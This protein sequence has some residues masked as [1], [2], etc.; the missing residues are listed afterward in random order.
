MIAKERDYPINIAKLEVLLK[1][2]PQTHP[3]YKDVQL[4]LYKKT[5][6]FRG[7]QNTDYPLSFLSPN[8]YYILHDLRLPVEHYYFQI[9]T[10]IL[11]K[12]LLI[13]LEIKNVAGTL[14]FDQDF[15]QL[16]KIHEGNEEA[17]S[18]PIIQVARQKLL[19]EKWLATKYYSDLPIENLI[20]ISN[21]QTIIKT[22]PPGLKIPKN[23]IN[24]DSLPFE[25]SK[26]EKKYKREL[27]TD[28]EIKKLIRQLKKD[29]TPT[30]FDVLT[31]FQI[32]KNCLIKGIFCPQCKK[33]SFKRIYGTWKCSI[34]KYIDKYAHID[35]IKDYFL[36]FGR[37][38]TNAE[39]R[40][41]I[42]FDNIY[43]ISRLLNK[44][45]EESVG[46]NKGKKYVISEE[47]FSNSWSKD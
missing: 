38:I 45:S 40:E 47:L 33:P 15:K 24:K 27:L 37:E 29:H 25:I 22:S 19:L 36:L 13:N 23:I 43:F 41:F 1:R 7:E 9:D 18:N 44:I 10:L 8:Q 2:L 6:G 42:N 16:I 5:A 31:K 39:L 14:V 11:S 12:N 32:N 21:P 26:L 30:E 34:C 35:A 3:K 17:I 28:K 46:K 20:V 4:E